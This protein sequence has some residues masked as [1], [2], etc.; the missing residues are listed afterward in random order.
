MSSCPEFF[1]GATDEAKE[2]TFINQDG[3]RLTYTNWI[4]NQPDNHG[5]AEH[6]TIMTGSGLADVPADTQ[7][8]SVCKKGKLLQTCHQLDKSLC[9]P[10]S[11]IVCNKKKL[12]GIS[13]FLCSKGLVSRRKAL[14]GCGNSEL[15][16]RYP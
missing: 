8:C 6:Y 12:R 11:F 13:F 3:S 4:N 10:Q 9:M 7:R 15:D 1:I 5:G 2:G 16:Q 14:R